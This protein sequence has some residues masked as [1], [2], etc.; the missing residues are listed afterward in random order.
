LRIL[1]DPEALI[2]FHAECLVGVFNNFDWVLQPNAMLSI[3]KRQR[4]A[5]HKI[6]IFRCLKVNS[7]SAGSGGLRMTLVKW[8]P[9]R[10]VEK[11]QNR[12][13]R[14]FEDSFGH[15]RNPDPETSL[16][17][18]RPPVDIYETE[19]GIVLAAELPGVGKENISV[20][21]KDNILT[22][23]GERTANQNIRGKNFYRH[24]RCYGTF[25]RSF[26]LQQN[27]QPN[28]IKATF[29]DGV[30]EIEIPKPEEEQPRQ[31]S[32]KVE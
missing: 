22:L 21:V 26:T 6:F 29:K 1:K 16:C 17:A 20:E 15:T 4:L 23:K 27:I 11:L 13:N 19:N 3:Q 24:E 12:I 5:I 28:L 10:D 2:Y 7:G 9:F 18:W 31:I 8:D 30:L 25:Q 32:V 14:M